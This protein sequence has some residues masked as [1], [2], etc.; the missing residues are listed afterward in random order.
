VEGEQGADG[1]R[2]CSSKGLQAEASQTCGSEHQAYNEMLSEKARNQQL[3]NEMVEQLVQT[4]KLNEKL[5]QIK[6]RQE[7]NSQNAA[8]RSLLPFCAQHSAGE[9]NSSARASGGSQRRTGLK[10][11][12]RTQQQ[13]RTLDGPNSNWP[14]R[15]AGLQNAAASFKVRPSADAYDPSKIHTMQPWLINGGAPGQPIQHVLP[16]GGQAATPLALAN[17]EEMLTC[18]F[19]SQ[20]K[21][22]FTNEAI[23]NINDPTGAS[24]NWQKQPRTSLKL[25]NPVRGKTPNPQSML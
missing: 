19:R 23:T 20:I 22:P 17:V 3:I 10:A 5:E 24:P 16:Q 14:Q 11:K 13:A 25:A 18:S 7:N 1:Q 15:E 21:S 2:S 4:K 6:K 9:A 12:L 8:K